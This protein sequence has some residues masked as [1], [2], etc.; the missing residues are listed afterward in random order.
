M[1][2]RQR[3]AAG[4]AALF[5]LAGTAVASVAV[6]GVASADTP[7]CAGSV[8]VHNGVLGQYCS[9]QEIVSAG[10]DLAVPNKAGA[11]ARVTFKAAGTTNAQEDFQFFNPAGPH[12]DNE[13]LAEWSPRGIASGW[14]LT[15]S[16]SGRLVVLKKLADGGSSA[17]QQWV[18]VGPDASGAYAWVSALNGRAISDPDGA[19]YT[20]AILVSGSG[21]PFTYEQ[22]CCSAH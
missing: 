2:V 16:N 8:Q 9:S 3:L 6:A 14:F 17:G 20:R 10:V 7:A 12:P 4:L 5:L 18:A 15:V 11:Y 1:S 21:S 19:P 22:T 13:K